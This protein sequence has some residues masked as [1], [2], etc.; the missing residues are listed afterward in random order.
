MAPAE[1]ALLQLLRLSPRL[2]LRLVRELEGYAA[3]MR[4]EQE[5]LELDDVAVPAGDDADPRR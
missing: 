5:L 4:P 2:L 3:P 1:E